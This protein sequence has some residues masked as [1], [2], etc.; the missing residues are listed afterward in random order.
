MAEEF[1]FFPSVTTNNNLQKTNFDSLTVIYLEILITYK[2]G[3][4]IVELE[5]MILM[6]RL[7]GNLIALCALWESKSG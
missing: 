6:H 4:N 3:L 1:F 2:D 7:V 5:F